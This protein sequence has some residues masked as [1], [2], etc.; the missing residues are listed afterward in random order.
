M[1]L[2]SCKCKYKYG[3]KWWNPSAMPQWTIDLAAR[4]KELAAIGDDFVFDGT[5]ANRY[6]DGN[7]CL[8]WHTD[9]EDLLKQNL[10]ILQS[11]QFRLDRRGPSCLRRIFATF[12]ETNKIT[13]YTRLLK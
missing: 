8:W 12:L 1:T 10:G 9:D 5:N 4:V 2:G 11:L 7:Q 3:G 13:M 6:E